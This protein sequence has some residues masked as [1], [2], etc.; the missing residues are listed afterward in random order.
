MTSFFIKTFCSFA[1]LLA[2][3][4]P[5]SSIAAETGNANYYSNVFHGR[6]TASGQIYNK[7]KLTAAHRKLAFGTKVRVTDLKNKKSVI[8]TIN[9][10]GPSVRGVV[11]DL[12]R[13][14]A[15]RIDLIKKGV[16]RVKIEVLR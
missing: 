12:S 11:I 6:K 8:V 2:M 7:N 4:A 13:A 3:L 16:S 9:D 1:F 15:K 14:A 10:R 5:I